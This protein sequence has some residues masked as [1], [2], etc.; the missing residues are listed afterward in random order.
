MFGLR[1]FLLK[2]YLYLPFCDSSGQIM[3]V[4]STKRQ[5]VIVLNDYLFLSIPNHKLTTYGFEYVVV[6]YPQFR[7]PKLISIQDLLLLFYN[8]E[9]KSK[10]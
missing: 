6:I 9:F 7:L 10:K 1:S 8:S 3:C 2:G 5:V 4:I